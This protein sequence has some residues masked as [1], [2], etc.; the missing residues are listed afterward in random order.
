MESK[1]HLPDESGKVK[2]TRRVAT[3]L[4]E[5]CSCFVCA[6][7]L[8]LHFSGPNVHAQT[9]PATPPKGQSAAAPAIQYQPWTGDFDGM[10]KRRFI[11]VLVSFSKTQYYV[12]NGVQRGKLLGISERI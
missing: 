9:V 10:L 4:L 12:V 5:N 2:S 6:L 11:R 1:E 7:L 8:V 3:K